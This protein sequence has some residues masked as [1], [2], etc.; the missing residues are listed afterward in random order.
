MFP[1]RMD[2][3]PAL[4]PI[5]RAE[6][7]AGKV[8]QRLRSAL[9]GGR[10]VP[11][12]KLVHRLLATELG[13]SP[14]PVREALLRLV[15]EGALE[16]DARGIAWV[17]RLEVER[18]DEIMDL[19]VELEGRA[20]ARA[21]LLA[22]PADIAVLTEI[23]ARL[24]AGRHS[25]DRHT[26]L[27]ENERFHFGVIALARMPVLQRVVESLWVQVGPTINL[28]FSGPRALSA[29]GHPHDALLAALTAHD[30]EAAREALRRDLC[31][32]ARVL[33]PLLAREAKPVTSIGN[34][35]L[36]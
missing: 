10:L 36:G 31:E 7:L 22:T 4:Q 15:S 34:R 18:Y 28:L 23:Q 14:T 1:R 30:A 5:D 12:Q 29:M 26:V 20:A 9:V 35:V 21:A 17:P 2:I 33:S 3:E 13:V 16:L 27:A 24:L 25:A 8:Y 19:R 11:G 6:S 32:H